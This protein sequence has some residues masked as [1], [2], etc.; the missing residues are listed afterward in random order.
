MNT[1]NHILPTSSVL[2]SPKPVVVLTAV[3]IMLLVTVWECSS[4]TVR[5]IAATGTDLVAAG[6]MR[7]QQVAAG[8]MTVLSKSREDLAEVI[9][10]SRDGAWART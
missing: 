5:C 9:P 6:K 10:L 1:E 2:L 8:T 7:V 4:T 3:P